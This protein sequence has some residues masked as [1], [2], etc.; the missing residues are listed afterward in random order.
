MVQ[1]VKNLTTI[2]EDAGSIPGLT[3]WVKESGIA[4]SYSVG[5]RLSSDLAS[6]WLWL[7]LAAGSCSSDSSPSLG[8]SICH[9]CNPGE[10]KKK[11]KIEH[12]NV[13][14]KKA[15]INVNKMGGKELLQIH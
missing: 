5:H 6:L 2:H 14:N 12:S 7:R 11:E 4:M 1:Q 10:K 13:T 8:T 3:Q 9:R 15:Y